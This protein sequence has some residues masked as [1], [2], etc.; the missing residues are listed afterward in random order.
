MADLVLGEP[1]HIQGDITTNR[2]VGARSAR[3]LE[4]SLGFGR[5]RLAAGWWILLLKQQLQPDDFIFAG[6]TL[7]SGGRE[8]LP[9]A[10]PDLDEQRPHVQ[11]VMLREMGAANLR[12]CKVRSL[13]S[14]SLSGPDRLVK[15][16]P[17][18]R[19]AR[20]D[21][22]P[23]VDYPMGGGGL[24]WTLIRPCRFLVAARV[25]ENGIAC[26]PRFSV[27]LGES[28]SYDD[29]ARLARYLEAA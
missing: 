13:A 14:V 25:D 15:V 26:T 21:T 29:R 23:D 9:A 11:D 19:I 4:D 6:L 5:G 8:G 28:A 22:R 1:A 10:S 3:A 17:V 12:E 18:T 27:F 7:R 2:W 16:V 24:Q 20:A